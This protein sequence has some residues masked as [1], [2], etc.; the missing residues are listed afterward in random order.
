LPCADIEV[1]NFVENLDNFQA[2]HNNHSH[3]KELDLCTPFCVCSCC[4]TPFFHLREEISFRLILNSKKIAS[5]TQNY[6]PLEIS[7]FVASIWQPP[8]IV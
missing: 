1:D 8:Q 2:N 7:N 6:K 5:K 4:G 3:E